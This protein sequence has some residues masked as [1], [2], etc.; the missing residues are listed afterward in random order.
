MRQK[1]EEAGGVPRAVLGLLGFWATGLLGYWVTGLL[2]LTADG[3]M[4]VL[5]GLVALAVL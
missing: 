3:I 1:A 4:C 2:W 5:P